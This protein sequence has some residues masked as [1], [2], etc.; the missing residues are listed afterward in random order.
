MASMLVGEVVHNDNFLCYILIR[1]RSE[2]ASNEGLRAFPFEIFHRRRVRALSLLVLRLNRRDKLQLSLMK[3][4][5][6]L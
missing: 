2:D 4:P 5:T 1:N 6:N 3:L